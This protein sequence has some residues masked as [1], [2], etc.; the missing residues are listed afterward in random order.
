MYAHLCTQ[1]AQAK[2]SLMSQAAQKVTEAMKT[3]SHFRRRVYKEKI[4]WE[5]IQK[6]EMLGMLN[7][8]RVQEDEM[9]TFYAI[10]RNCYFAGLN[11]V[12]CPV[13]RCLGG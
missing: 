3:F 8:C 10:L 5:E 7:A 4:I 13:D 11:K 2:T 9:R 12:V 6:V 1:E